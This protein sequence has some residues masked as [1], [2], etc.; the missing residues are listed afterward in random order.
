MP[1]SFTAVFGEPDDYQAALRADGVLLFLVTDA[2]PFRA[3]LTEIVLHR[4]RL[5]EGDEKTARIAVIAVPEQM[6][7]VV[8]APRGRQSAV[9]GGIEP[10]AGEILTAGPGERF[11]AW[12]RGPGRWSTLLV[13]RRD[14]VAYG[15]VL[16]GSRFV[17][18]PGLARCR[19]VPTGA[20]NLLGLHRAAIGIAKNGSEAL[21]GREA[22]HGLEQQLI[23]ALVECLSPAAVHHETPANRRHRDLM[24]RFEA[25][26]EAGASRPVADFPAALGVSERLLRSCCAT[27]L[28]MSPGH[29]R[30]R[31]ALQQ[32]RRDPTAADPGLGRR[33][34]KNS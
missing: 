16:T 6:V 12:T 29:Y 1:G 34:I 9:W 4:L 27:Q 25:L 3:R 5:A 18:P 7:L 22:A 30:R 33:S 8:L 32:V 26:L 10:A 13:P 11:H 15:A 17:V 28:G 24:A 31:R 21:A 2:G 20:E 23:H 14:L 19:P